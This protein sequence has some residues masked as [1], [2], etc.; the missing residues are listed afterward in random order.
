SSPARSS[1]SSTSASR[2]RSAPRISIVIRSFQKRDSLVVIAARRD[3][4][5][6]VIRALA[7]GRAVAA[8]RYPVKSALLLV[9][10]SGCFYLDPINQ[11]PGI[12]IVP[13]QDTAHRTDDVMFTA[14]ISDP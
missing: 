2:A 5:P 10:V 11:R 12:S 4:P 7:R 1:N 8:Q 14:E 13:A 6:F 3:P 9:A